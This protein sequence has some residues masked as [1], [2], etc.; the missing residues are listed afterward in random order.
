MSE[1]SPVVSVIIPTYNRKESLLRTLDS[2]ARQTYPADRMEVIVVDDGSTDG[3]TDAIA[4]RYAAVHLIQQANQGAAAARNAGVGLARGE[5]LVFVDD[6]VTLHETYLQA[7]TAPCL[8]DQMT[9]TMGQVQPGPEIPDSV[10]SAVKAREHR[11]AMCS[12]VTVVPFT[13]CV[14]NN[15]CV[16][17]SVFAELGGW[18][19]VVGD[20]PAT[21]ADV[22][23]GYVAATHG[24]RLILVPGAMLWHH[25]TWGLSLDRAC[26]RA[27]NVGRLSQ[28]L[29]RAFP[30][31]EEHVPMFADKGPVRWGEDSVA[32]IARK[33]VRS[34]ASSQP[35]QALIRWFTMILERCWPNF[36][37]LTH[38]YNWQ[39]SACIRKGYRQGLR[40]MKTS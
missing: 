11:E 37:V 1:P 36:R 10:W 31:L 8:L 30:E 7:V 12:D 28:R 22:L 18:E 5:L 4:S 14:S 6:D 27:Q 20:G 32:I 35:A 34:L 39:V 17:R 24:Y 19:N 2:L 15:L 38:L 40:E 26:E 25:D 16:C 21:W 9:L 29:F 3:T 33:A 13:W 23:F